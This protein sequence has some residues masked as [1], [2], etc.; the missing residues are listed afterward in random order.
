MFL[1]YSA[2]AIRTLGKAIG[3]R[4]V[5]KDKHLAIET[6][7]SKAAPKNLYTNVAICSYTVILRFSSCDSREFCQSHLYLHGVL[8]PLQILQTLEDALKAWT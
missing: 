1:E 3:H 6:A 8:L 7:G 5:N 2:V 4:M